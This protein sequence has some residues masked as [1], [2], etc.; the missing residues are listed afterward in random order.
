MW[1]LGAERS[2]IRA[3]WFSDESTKHFPISNFLGTIKLFNYQ[4]GVINL[5]DM[6]FSNFL[7]A[8]C[9]LIGSWYKSE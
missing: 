2:L 9:T 8:N 1:A 7:M 3:D 4:I 6:H 5:Q